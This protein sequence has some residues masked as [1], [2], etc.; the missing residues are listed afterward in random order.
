MEYD[1]D[2]SPTLED[3]EEKAYFLIRLLDDDTY[4]FWLGYIISMSLH[5]AVCMSMGLQPHIV[6][7][8]LDG[9]R[10]DR[11][12]D[13]PQYHLRLA[14]ARGAIQSGGLEAKLIDYIDYV[15]P[16]DFCKWAVSDGHTLPSELYELLRR[17]GAIP[18]KETPRSVPTTRPRPSKQD[19][20]VVVAF[21]R[22]LIDQGRSHK[23]AI[24]KTMLHFSISEKTVYT[25]RKDCESNGCS[26]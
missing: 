17:M 5:N 21:Y 3:E 18:P 9:K 4:K 22:A 15:K 23:Q 10:E 24:A 16:T 6:Q 14:R 25:Y 20:Q 7:Q 8:L 12:H 11:F 26:P 1:F 13:C 2:S 19:K